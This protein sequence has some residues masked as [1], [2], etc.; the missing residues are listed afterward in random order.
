MTCLRISL[1]VAMIPGASFA[2]VDTSEW[3]CE[4]CPFEEGYRADLS[5]GA[6][7]V[8]DDAARFGNAT[9]YDEK[10]AYANV[11]GT[12]AYA[13]AG[14]RLNWMI[15]DLGLSSRALEIDGG[16]QG[17]FGF[18]IGYREQPYRLFDST[19]TI[20]ISSSSD[21][22]S[23]PA[24]WVAAG[25]TAG[26]SQLAASSRKQNIESDRQILDLGASWSPGDDF[27]VFADF[28]RQNRDGI[29]ITGGSGFTN[30]SLLPRWFDYETDQI[31]AGI[32]YATSQGSLSLSY[33]GSF[34]TNNATALN[35]ETPFV[36]SPGA[37]L[38]RKSV[39]PD[40]DFQQLS[41][42]GSY[43]WVPWD[44]VAAFSIANGRG[45]QN[46]SF[47]PYTINP[48]VTAGTLPRNSLDARVD[49]SNYA[50]TVTARPFEKGRI[51]F[52]YRQ[53]E[54]D[55]ASP[56]SDWN[57]IIVDLFDAGETERNTPYSFERSR[58]SLSGE[59]LTW[60]DIRLS[61]GY[62]R[63]VLKRD[64][65]EVAKQTIDAGWG[66]IRW[67]PL[68]WLDLRAKG[69]TSERD[70]DRY[71]ESVGVSLGQNPLM[72]KYNLAY[73]FRSYG[74]LFASIS[75]AEAKW[76]LSSTV[77]VADDR[78][79]KSQLGITDSEEVRA[80]A[81][82]SIALSTN[83]SLYLVIGYEDVDALQLG[84]EQF[85]TWDWQ[86][87]HNDSFEHVG[88]G[89]RW[90]QPESKVDFRFNYSRGAGKTEIRLDSLSGGLSRLPDLKSTLDSL[91]L[92][93][94]YRW[95]ERLEGT[96]NLRYE[97][98]KLQDWAL[99]APDALPTI[100]TVGAQPY[101]YDLWALGI[102]VRYSFGAREVALP[103]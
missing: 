71:N 72:R 22:L 97:R 39:A 70:I 98:F 42:S 3:L 88:F 18:K 20:F 74:E 79:N 77:L 55:N 9:G 50:L 81:D 45:E 25:N 43:K 68:D 33:Y 73:R 48:N 86:A 101:D 46:E 83:T 26:L 76:S 1:L 57:R 90:R 8:N 85:A 4:S 21:A 75:P 44:I 99:V 96:L 34:F 91:R 36:T 23:L 49:T 7:Y 17:L 12:G 66:Q 89:G 56:Q 58:L 69:G 29:K 60:K 40:N 78:Y 65:Q 67:R 31:D 80:T 59:L 87:T 14:Y 103:D 63:K 35:W 11:D 41:L 84:S 102:G 64:F 2:Q 100:L 54:R 37:E 28:Q 61:G 93:T 15:E 16:Q 24:G 52:T 5:G 92:E 13:N 10:S 51:R 53:D 95:T 94:T 6:T 38:L 82:L 19:S 62:E 32:R 47:L 30:S 27:Q